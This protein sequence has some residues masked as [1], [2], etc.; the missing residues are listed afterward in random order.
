MNP[1]RHPALPPG[2]VGRRLGG[3]PDFDLMMSAPWVAQ[4]LGLRARPLSRSDRRP[5]RPCMVL[6]FL[7]SLWQEAGYLSPAT[8]RAA[9]LA[10]ARID[11][12]AG[13]RGKR[14]L[15]A[16][17][18]QRRKRGMPRGGA[19][20]SSRQG[21]RSTPGG[22][23]ALLVRMSAIGADCRPPPRISRPTDRTNLAAITMSGRQDHRRAGSCC[24]SSKVAMTWRQRRHRGAP[25]RSSR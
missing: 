19:A 4:D 25:G 22:T 23:D 1:N 5:D 11:P 18:Q 2:G 24:T 21:R 7:A 15:A 14:S 8:S 12:P 10:P 20:V 13:S 17:P 16:D 9:A 3:F 6:H